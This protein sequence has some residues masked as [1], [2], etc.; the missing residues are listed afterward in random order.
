MTDSTKDQ[1][2]K[3]NIGFSDFKKILIKTFQSWIKNEPLRESA[4]IAFFAIISIPALMV[5][6]VNFLGLFLEK[7]K[8]G[9]ELSELIKQAINSETSEQILSSVKQAGQMK[10]GFLSTTL[11][12]IVIV[13]AS[14]RVFIHLQKTLDHI[15]DV[16][17]VGKKR[18]QTLINNLFSIGLIILI[19]ILLMVSM[20]V[21]TILA[22]AGAYLQ[23]VFPDEIIYLFHVLDFIVSLLVMSILFAVIFKY[24]PSIHITWR[25]VFSGSVLTGFLFMVLKYGLSFYIARASPG[26]AYGAAGTIFLIMLWVAVSSMIIF[27]GAEFTKQYSNY[28]GIEPPS[29]KE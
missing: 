13:F 26:S 20:F 11:G 17:S 22:S 16:E 3:Q 7:E 24:L 25:Q 14:T 1:S 9:D 6:I 23:A 29:D 12:I 21:S 10:E 4:V 18:V 2:N 19:G 28:L 8:V 15:W 27:F 5:L